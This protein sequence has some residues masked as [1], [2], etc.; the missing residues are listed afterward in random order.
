M[1]S[2][3]NL[4][5]PSNGGS[6]GGAPGTRPPPLRTKI[7]LISCSFWENPANLYVGL[8]VGAP[9][10]GESCIRPCLPYLCLSGIVVHNLTK[11][12]LINSTKALPLNSA[13][14]VETFKENSIVNII[15]LE[16]G[17]NKTVFQ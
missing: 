6:K 9:S 5:I 13:N 2:Y 8:G 15:F 1:F 11:Q 17:V 16:Y 14:I 3:W 10:Y 12:V 7:F 4:K